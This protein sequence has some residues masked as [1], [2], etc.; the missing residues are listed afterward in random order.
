MDFK[1]VKKG[2][3]KEEVDSYLSKMTAEFESNLLEQKQRI[4]EQKKQIAIYEKNIKAY[5]EKSSLVTKSI[6]NAVAKAEEI[7]KLS[8]HKYNQEIEQLKTFH[9]K[10]LTYYERILQKYPL[11]D[12]LISGIKFNQQM[13]KILD[14]AE[15]PAPMIK[16]EFKTPPQA[17]FEKE[18]DRLKEKQIGYIKVRTNSYES[19]AEDNSDDLLN[20]I[21][22]DI[23]PDSSILSAIDD[24]LVVGDF[25]PIDRIN[26]YFSI[27]EAKLD[28]LPKETK[29]AEQIKEK[30]EEPQIARKV[31]PLDKIPSN[32]G[33]SFDE[34]LH[35]KQEL[36]DIMKDLGLLLD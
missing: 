14:R 4:F 31:S 36:E 7:E 11:D 28:V 29:V 25:D 12:Q 21:I 17:Q 35:P 20:E 24:S 13:S 9:D 15:A 30:V 10:W 34:A 22:P 18:S 8:R 2:Y 16:E 33:F 27:N 32:S 19:E 6:Y 1:I 23:D 3:S 26:K 5:R